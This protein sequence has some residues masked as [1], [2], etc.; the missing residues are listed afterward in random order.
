MF[1]C[2]QE[3]LTSNDPSKILKE[4]RKIIEEIR[5]KCRENGHTTLFIKSSGLKSKPKFYIED[6]HYHIES[7]WLHDMEGRYSLI[8]CVFELLRFTRDEPTLSREKN[9]YLEGIT[10]DEKKFKVIVRKERSGY[11]LQSFF[12]VRE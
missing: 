2:R 6:F 1:F 4:A 9:Y 12:R 5:D 10:A 8:P 7:K 3:S 11:V